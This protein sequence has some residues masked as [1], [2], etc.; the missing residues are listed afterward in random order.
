[1]RAPRA[2]CLPSLINGVT[3]SPCSLK[4]DSAKRRGRGQSDIE[5]TTVTFSGRGG[6]H[7][8][9]WVGHTCIWCGSARGC[10]RG[11]GLSR[12]RC[13]WG[14]DPPRHPG[15]TRANNAPGNRVLSYAESLE[16]TSFDEGVFP[17][18]LPRLGERQAQGLNFTGIDQL[19]GMGWTAAGML[20][21]Q[22]GTPLGRSP[23]WSGQ[24]GQSDSLPLARSPARSH[25]YPQCE[26]LACQAGRSASPRLIGL[27]R[28]ATRLCRA[29]RAVLRSAAPR[30][31]QPT[32]WPRTPP[33]PW[34]RSRLV[35]ECRHSRIP[36]SR[37]RHRRGRPPGCR[38]ARSGRGRPA[39]SCPH[40]G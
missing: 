31:V 20:G 8:R 21:S 22:C 15:S 5:M 7:E 3:E 1:M 40:P 16:R 12:C 36:G 34:R 29:S 6:R 23:G 11:G 30:K 28:N 9:C 27:A 2:A 13:G 17:G 10:R 32:R 14:D 35:P 37:S 26:S 18:V 24:G 38:R 33:A 39:R 19:P 4:Y 25:A